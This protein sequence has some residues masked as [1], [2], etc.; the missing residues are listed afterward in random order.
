VA[1]S[2]FEVPYAESVRMLTQQASALDNLRSRA[3]TI[4]AAAALVT[5][6]LGAQAFGRPSAHL[7][8][9]GWAAIAALFGVLV[10]TLLVLYPWNH[11][12]YG[13]SATEMIENLDATQPPPDLE[14]VQRG[15]AM[16]L[17]ADFRENEAM[18]ERLAWFFKLA[19]I[20]TVAETALWIINLESIS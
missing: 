17:E 15:T 5:T 18:L 16:N 7:T 8:T 13:E 12:N 11:W 3:S 6:F 4:L 2:V 9:W 20:L 14:R 1:G 19:C 10:C